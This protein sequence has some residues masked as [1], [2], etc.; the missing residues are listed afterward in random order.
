M[1]LRILTAVFIILVISAACTSAPPTETIATTPELEVIQ[2]EALPEQVETEPPAPTGVEVQETASMEAEPSGEQSTAGQALSGEKVFLIVPDETEARFLVDEVLLG[3]PFTV[4]GVTSAVGGEIRADLNA[5]NNAQA[6]VQVD[7][8]TLVTDNERRNGAI[9]RWILETGEPA[10]Q[11]AEFTSVSVSGIPEQLEVG[12][13]FDFQINGDLTV[14]GIT[15]P[16]T[17]D[18]TATLVSED[19]LEGSAS[20][21]IL[22]TDFTT[23]PSLPPQ[24][25]SVED[26]TTL[27][28][29]FVAVAE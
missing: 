25:A 23:I 1:K 18:G 17:F 5:P 28:I 14:K 21:T 12:Q 26:E 11:T 16:L 29:D 2:E 13:T 15:R 4:V 20:T 22:Y 7:L 6:D 27:E 8:T 19:R 9:Q 10:N 24:V 3:A